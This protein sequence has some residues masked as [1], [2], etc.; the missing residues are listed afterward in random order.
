MWNRAA[1]ICVLYRYSY[2]EAF[3]VG[4]GRPS[5]GGQRGQA[6]NLPLRFYP[7]LG[8]HGQCAVESYIS[9]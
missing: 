7:A 6:R 2:V 3:R 1:L 8:F 5:A 9:R 4:A